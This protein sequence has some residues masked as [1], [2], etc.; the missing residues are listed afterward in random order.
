M[1]SEV[2]TEYINGEPF[3]ETFFNTIKESG[4]VCLVNFYQ[5]IWPDYQDLECLK[6]E[7]FDNFRIGDVGV[8]VKV[9]FVGKMQNGTI[10][11][12]DWKTG[13]NIDGYDTELQM[14]AY[15]IWAMQYYKKGPDEIQSEFVSLK[16]GE[17][18]PFQI[19]EDQLHAMKDIIKTDFEM[20]NASYEYEDFLP[21]PDYHECLSCQFARA[22]PDSDIGEMR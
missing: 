13:A 1:A 20:M 15:V 22:C 14:A 16:T 2:F 21:N 4:K 12:T 17:K 18:K 6:H 9:D 5:D 3:N 8:T 19:D 7:K 11:L 10:V